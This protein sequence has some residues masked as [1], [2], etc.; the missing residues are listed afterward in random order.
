MDAILLLSAHYGFSYHKLFFSNRKLFFSNR[1]FPF[2]NRKFLYI[3]GEIGKEGSKLLQMVNLFSVIP[4]FLVLFWLI[5]FL[6][7]PKQN[8]SKRFLTFFLFLVLINYT[9]HWFYFNHK[10]SIYALFDS[11][12]VFTSLSVFPLYYYYIRLLTRDT[13]INWRWIWL[14]IPSFTLA[15]FSAVIYAMMTPDEIDTFIQGILY[16]KPGYDTTGS[17][18]LNLQK[19]RLNLFKVIYVLQVIFVL[20]FGLKLIKEYNLNVKSFYSNTEHK[21]LG[22]IKLLLLFFVFTAFISIVSNLVGKDYFINNPVMLAIPAITHSV[23][24]FG[25]SYAGYKQDFTIQHFN[26]DNENDQYAKTDRQV[27]ISR[28]EFDTLHEKLTY[29]FEHD[30][31]FKDMDLRLSDVA[32]QMGTNRTYVSRLINERLNKNFCD[33]VKEFRIN[34]A[35]SLLKSVDG[36]NL[37]LEE[38]ANMSGFSNNSTFYREFVRKNGI[39]PGKYREKYSKQI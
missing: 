22:P 36:E 37:L 5:L 10:Y 17:M 33:F 18:L 28:K 15:L 27:E 8:I 26:K 3:C 19:L 2:S 7:E 30:Q 6:I 38:I 12:W 4:V 32:A 11:I 1:K 31:I 20:Y 21:D 35:E 34:H 24:L 29:L 39:S 25:I 16:H 9:A 23:V 14:I 13:K